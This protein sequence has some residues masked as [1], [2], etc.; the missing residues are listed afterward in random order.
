MICMKCGQSLDRKKDFYLYKDGT[1][2]PIC[3]EC[4]RDAINPYDSSTF[5]P[6]LRSFDVPY[7]K[8]DWERKLQNNEKKNKTR[9]TIGQYL[10]LMTLCKFKELT[11][12]DS[13]LFAQDKESDNN[14]S[15][16]DV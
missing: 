12:A 15:T 1:S 6:Y 7:S 10:S 9:Y 5:L 13:Y 8:E 4:L 11:F 3:K 2:C 14:A 16:N